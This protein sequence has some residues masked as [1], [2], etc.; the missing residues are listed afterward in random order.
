MRLF[1][2]AARRGL[3][4]LGFDGADMRLLWNFFWMN[5]RDRYLGSSLGSVWAIA[6]PLLLLIIY[7]FV[8]GFVFRA[9]LPGAETTLSYTIWLIAGY[10]P[11]LASTEA[12]MAGSVSVVSAAGLVKNMTF[13]AEVLPVAGALTGLIPFAVCSVFLGI[14]L[15]ADGNALSWHALFVVPIAILQFGFLAGLSLFFS[16]MNVF[17][18]DL[19]IALPNFL[20]IVLFASPIFYPIESMPSLLQVVS[21]LNPFFIVSAAYR[22]ALVDHHVPSL[23]GLAYLAVL[24]VAVGF[25]GLRVFRRL[26]GYMESRL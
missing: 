24:V 15:V 20:T 12:I 14:L 13:K 21:F 18:R 5:V 8:F 3:R 4:K 25:L 26:K 2:Q 1:R 6:N 16:A 11:W 19:V 9:K 23:I 10:G 7:T 17:V 22:R